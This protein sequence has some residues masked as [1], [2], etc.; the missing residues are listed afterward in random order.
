MGQ[1]EIMNEFGIDIQYCWSKAC[2]KEDER[3]A[4]S[5]QPWEW[6]RAWREFI[7]MTRPPE[8][9]YDVLNRI[10]QKSRSPYDR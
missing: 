7:L 5:N 6:K 2:R 9:A 1:H 3:A 4:L 8:E 10:A